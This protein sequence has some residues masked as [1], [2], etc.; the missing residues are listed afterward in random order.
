[1]ILFMT[2]LS[3][4]KLFFHI[5]RQLSLEELTTISIWGGLGRQGS[6]G[7]QM[8]MASYYLVA[9]GHY[10]IWLYYNFYRSVE[11]IFYST[12]LLYKTSTAGCRLARSSCCGKTSFWA[13]PSPCTALLSWP[14]ASLDTYLRSFKYSL[15]HDLLNYYN[16]TNYK[17]CICTSSHKYVEG[18]SSPKKNSLPKIKL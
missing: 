3:A 7:L 17:H 6:R 1:M 15:C 10:V 2:L 8:G 18:V 12:N 14:P 4:L 5:V 16:I 11:H 13:T 9:N